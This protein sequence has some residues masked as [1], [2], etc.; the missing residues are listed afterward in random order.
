M[1]IQSESPGGGPSAEARDTSSHLGKSDSPE[2]SQATGQ[3]QA[4]KFAELNGWEISPD[5]FTPDVIGCEEAYWN[6]RGH[7]RWMDHPLYF[8]GCL[9][10][11]K[12]ARCIAIVGQPY[13]SL[14]AHRN[15]LYAVAA[16]YG[17]LCW[18]VPPNPRASFWSPG[19]TL[20]VVMTLPD[21]E[22][23]WLPEQGQQKHAEKLNGKD[24]GTSNPEAHDREE[25]QNKAP[26]KRDEK[27]VPFTITA[28]PYTFPS[29]AS[30]PQYDWLLGRHL[31]RGE[32]CGTAA[33]GG[34][35]KSSL[36]IVEALAMTSG[37]QL[38]HDAVPREPIRVVL[39]NLEDKQNTMDKRI[40]AAMRHY[41]LCKE[42]IG[43]RLIV[44]GKGEIK[45]KIAVQVKAGDVWRNQEIIDA[46]IELMTKHKADVLSIDSF[47]RTHSVAENDNS[48]IE[49]VVECFEEIAVAANCAVHLWHHTRKSGGQGVSVES[50]R[51]AQAF[52]DACRAVRILETMTSEEAKKLKIP[53]RRPYFRAFNGKL[54]FALATDESQWL[55]TASVRIDNGPANA[56]GVYLLGD[57]LGVAEC[58]QHPGTVE[59]DL[60]EA[61]VEAIKQL[62]GAAAWRE[63]TRAS[64]WVGK[65]IAQVLSL[66]PEDDAALIKT[67]LKRLIEMGA[68]KR[69]PG[70]DKNRE[71]R[72]FIVPCSSPAAVG[73]PWDSNMPSNA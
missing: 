43:D 3:N 1:T 40:A 60:S 58:W 69:E 13:G 71:A 50:A 68:L 47:I 67:T 23:R 25:R 10:G 70:R 34:T 73:S 9:P 52:I 2:H 16:K 51:G 62:V 57:N 39:I 14:D 5:P 42:D 66:D 56:G 59:A 30:I 6:P 36:A 21:V 41:K 31:L 72:V 26:E 63:D 53:N 33:M 28:A 15:E 8:K 48:A 46:L 7:S 49:E 24:R 12:T 38:T 19:K 29:E 64:M 37:K 32:V 55:V 22:V 4:Q 35:G 45:I 27:R 18:H 44:L 17:C 61:N 11:E 20:F 54:N 65:A